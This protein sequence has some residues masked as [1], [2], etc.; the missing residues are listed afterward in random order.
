MLN[1]YPHQERANTMNEEPLK[2]AFIEI[3]PWCHKEIVCEQLN[4]MKM[5]ARSCPF[6]SELIEQLK[7][8]IKVLK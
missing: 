3:C 2:I 4:Y 8:G 7:L 5:H 1:P 6:F